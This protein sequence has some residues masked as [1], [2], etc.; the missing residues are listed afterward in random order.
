M[1][2]KQEIQALP[3]GDIPTSNMSLELQEYIKRRFE[4]V[5]KELQEKAELVA[6]PQR[7]PSTNGY[8]S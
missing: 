6:N 7:N 8:T 1:N 3:Y 2:I 5:K 4:K